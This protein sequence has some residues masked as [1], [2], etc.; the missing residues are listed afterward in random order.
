LNPRGIL[1]NVIALHQAIRKFSSTKQNFQFGSSVT[2]VYDLAYPIGQIITVNNR[3]S[4]EQF[5]NGQTEFV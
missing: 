3:S 4:P 5:F 1:A 2:S